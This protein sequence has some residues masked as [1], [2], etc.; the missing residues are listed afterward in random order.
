SFPYSTLFRSLLDFL[1]DVQVEEP[2]AI[3]AQDERLVVAHQL[4]VE[5]L[6]AHLR[7]IDR[8]ALRQERRGDHEDDQKHEH[9]VDIR[10]DV[11]LAHQPPMPAAASHRTPPAAAAASSRAALRWKI[12]V[13]SSMNVS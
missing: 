9:D 12:A 1:A 3:D 10:H 4:R 5:R 6:G 7:Q 8:D 11:H 13:S 2:V